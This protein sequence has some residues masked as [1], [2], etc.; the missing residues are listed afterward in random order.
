MN[1]AVS[2][3]SSKGREPSAVA[4]DKVQ[5]ALAAVRPPSGAVEEAVPVRDSRAA[6]DA[7]LIKTENN[8]I[9]AYE[10][11]VKERHSVAAQLSDWGEA[12]GDD[13]VSDISDKLGVIIAEFAEI[14]DWFA[15]QLEDSRSVLK[16]IRNI[17]QGV[18]PCRDQKAKVIDR[19]AHLRHSKPEAPEIVRLEQE[20]VRV[21][22]QNLV[23]EAQLT[24]ITRSK[25]KESYQLHFAAVQERAE[26]SIILAKYGCKLLDL[27][28]DAQIGPGEMS[29]G[30]EGEGA[31]RQTLVECE[32]E[33]A[34]WKPESEQMSDEGSLAASEGEAKQ[35]QPA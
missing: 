7:R 19:I 22:A 23:A 29:Q 32:N 6:T 33:L 16:H 27:L 35:S 2:L 25:L 34:R 5:A 18:Q 31:A 17:E 4:S 26:K 13:M 3:R 10:T 28:D 24:N 1:R 12:T 15:S 21:E 30:Y 8:V 20:L 9:S 11:A 14:E